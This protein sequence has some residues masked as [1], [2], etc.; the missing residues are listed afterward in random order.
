[1]AIF[2]HRLLL[3]FSII[4]LSQN[5]F[6][7]GAIRGIVTDK[8]TGETV[9]FANVFIAETGSGTTTDLD[10][11]YSLDVA[12]G[13]HSV[14]FSYLGYE[15]YTVNDVVVIEGEVTALDVQISEAGVVLVEVVVSAKQLRNTE[16]A[17][18]TL[19][20]KSTRLLNGV[21]SQTFS[22][23]GD[24]NAADA[25]KRVSGVS[26]ENGKYVYVRG[27]GDRYT[28]TL[29]N[30]MDIPGLD[31]DRNTVQMDIFPTNVIDNIIVYKTFTPDLP[32]DFTG[33]IVDIT[34]K[35][36]PEEAFTNLSA[37]I[38]YNSNANLNS[39]FLSYKGSD[40]YKFG[41]Y[42]GT[43]ALPFNRSNAIPDES[44]NSPVLQMLTGAFS[45]EMA[46]KKTDSGINSSFSF[47]HGNQKN[48]GKKTL[49]YVAALNYKNS[50]THYENAL[51]EN[52][53]VNPTNLIMTKEDQSSG[54]ISTNNVLLSGLFGAS[55]KNK[56][57]KLGASYLVIQN[58]EDNTASLV[59][60]DFDDNPSTIIRDV[61]QYSQRTI[62]YAKVNGKHS[63]SDNKLTANWAVSTT[64]IEVDEPDIR[65]TGFELRPDGEYLIQP[66]I[67][68]DI[69]R[70]FRNLNEQ[71]INGK[72]DLEYKFNQWSGLESKAKIGFNI[73]NK[74]RDYYIQ[75]YVFRVSSQNSL[76][77]EGNPDNLF[78]EENLWKPDSEQ[79]TYVKG[80]F[81]PSNTFNARQSVI[82]GY[83]MTELAMTPKLKTIFGARI[84]K[85]D[86]YYTGRNN[87]GTISLN[88]EKVLDELDILPS[89]NS[90]YQLG[91]KMNLRLS[92]NRTL[93]RPSFKEK[94]IAQ[95]QD[96]I[97]GRTFIGN[98]DL[99]ETKIHNI[100]LRWESFYNSAQMVSFSLFYKGL[101][102]P[103]ELES[104]NELSPDNYTPRNQ[105]NATVYGVEFEMRKQLGFIGKALSNFTVGMNATYVSSKI[106][107]ENA[108]DIYTSDTRQMVGQSPY[109]I[110]ASLGYQQAEKGFDA[111][112][113]YNV[114]GKK[115]SI[116]G[117]GVI[118]DVYEMPFN[119]LDAKASIKLGKE[120]NWKLS[121]SASNLLDSEKRFEYDAGELNTGE[122]I[123]SLYKPGT[124]ISMGLSYQFR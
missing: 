65:S 10:G 83:A 20:R 3:F 96:R 71:V 118:P 26:T 89:L 6:A 103:I 79:G 66:S 101:T 69:S 43:R 50:Y 23:I 31:P 47:S 78:I 70:T 35:D 63:L 60:L 38:S 117:I 113:G 18:A 19:Q 105:N 73:L 108:L 57:H 7:T 48:L 30:S 68:A 92:Y 104:Y 116:V 16:S 46:A 74:D 106:D 28:K 11:N 15:D 58:G 85:V 102:N 123:W 114:Q 88:D 64:F 53:I 98:L 119:S 95:I 72:F 44:T 14:T 33:G 107:R 91:E 86:N 90:I 87:L 29:L 112:I 100:D 5:L 17:I 40:T 110:N 22:K 75:D 97:T 76:N 39:D 52:Y 21:S 37:S 12:A 122:Y 99:E 42:D 4:F 54:V 51:F 84:E 67:G 56:R 1:M 55:I 121:V 82:A 94:S 9:P 77:L 81:E 124:T 120:A 34:T 62:H 13:N 61:L 59:A 24:S 2:K 80:N 45:E 93:A 111:N 25:I 115:L 109:L 36:F 49:G 41:F 32:A 8:S 27:L